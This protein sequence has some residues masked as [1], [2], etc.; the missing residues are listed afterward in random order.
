MTYPVH[1]CWFGNP[2]RIGRAREYCIKTW[3]KHIQDIQPM[4]WNEDNCRD[5]IDSSNY[6]KICLKQKQYA[7]LSDYVRFIR[8]YQYG[9]IYL[10]TDVELIKDITPL[11][12][13]TSFFFESD[14]EL[15]CGIIIAKPKSPMI[16]E[17]IKEYKRKDGMG[18][19][20]EQVP[21][22]LKRVIMART[23]SLIEDMASFRYEGELVK[24]LPKEYF[25]PYN[26]YDRSDE[27]RQKPF[28]GNITENT[29]GIHHWF[30][31]WELGLVQRIYGK[32]VRLFYKSA[33]FRFLFNKIFSKQP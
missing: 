14:S 12:R 22:V 23:N 6:A 26:P 19:R 3:G 29:Y 20:Y 9:G 8:L 32:L 10:D 31:G 15:G 17:V 33:I 18:F 16:G 11:G 5:I 30:K 27:I 13:T 24:M 1:Y 2:N 25:Y 21:G 28:L 7:F 4:L